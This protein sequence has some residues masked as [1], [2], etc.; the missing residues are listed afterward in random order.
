VAEKTM[1][2]GDSRRIEIGSTLDARYTV[3]AMCLHWAI[4]LFILFNLTLGYFM[5][6]FKQ[7]LRHQIVELHVS[8]GLTVLAL[9]ILRVAWRLTHAPPPFPAGMKRWEK[10]TAHAAHFAL[11]FMM[12][13]MPLTGWSI[14]SAHPPR[15]GAG[16]NVWGLLHIPALPPLANISLSIQKQVHDNLV[17]VHSI[18]GWIM[19]ALLVLHVA[20]AFKHQFFDMQREF[21]R[22]GIGR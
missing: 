17:E 9:T 7:P 18:G 4:A 14:I 2:T 20:A 15:P 12:F 10:C 22:M 3:I 1:A 13:A 16:A 8:S 11:Y 19:I 5:E 21:S 6:D